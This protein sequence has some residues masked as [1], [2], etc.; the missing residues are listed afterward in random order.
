[1]KWILFTG[2]WRLKTVNVEADVRAQVRRV[3]IRGDGIVTGGSTG[4]DYYALTE[5]LRYDPTGGHVKV[6]IPAGLE[7]YIRYYRKHL[8]VPPVTKKEIDNLEGALRVLKKVR[9]EHF[10]ELPSGDEVSEEMYTANR[11][12]QIGAVGEVYAFQV[13][14]SVSTELL[15]EKA[16]RRGVKIGLQRKYAVTEQL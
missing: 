2:A 8:C 3:L 14:N 5:A 7:S 16:R 1:M 11:I 4:V 12:R 15:V 6:F 10:F 9:P 13:N